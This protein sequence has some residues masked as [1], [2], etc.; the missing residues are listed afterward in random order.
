MR[1]VSVSSGSLDSDSSS[2]SASLSNASARMS[3][4]GRAIGMNLGAVAVI[5]SPL[6]G[7]AFDAALS[8]ELVSVV[9]FFLFALAGSSGAGMLGSIPDKALF[10]LGMVLAGY[11]YSEVLGC[12]MV[13][14]YLQ[15]STL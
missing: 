7:C 9:T 4:N 10:G 8:E 6:L 2:S 1:S 13:D 5:L 3:Q 14:E 12:W 11:E 15:K